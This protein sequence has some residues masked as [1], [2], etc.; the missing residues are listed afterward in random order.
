M[1]KGEPARFLVGHSGGKVSG[2]LEERFWDKVQKTGM[3]WVWTGCKQSQGYG[4]IRI[5]R[6]C[7]LAHRV[8]W[9]LTNGRIADNTQVLHKCDN[10]ACVRPDHLFLGSQQDNVDDMVAKGRNKNGA[11][12]E[13]RN[14]AKLTPG[15]V[16]WVRSL[17]S[18]NRSDLS[19][20]LG[21]TTTTVCDI[22]NRKTW[23]DI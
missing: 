2:T 4:Q 21:V 13:S 17:E 9:E 18:P 10:P 3:C 11:A 15:Q 19:K 14:S 12:F 16:L 8:S 20:L 22:I 5:K 1:R 6:K 7:E 23:R